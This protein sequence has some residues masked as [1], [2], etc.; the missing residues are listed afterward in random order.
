MCVEL[1]AFF[2]F[3]H[4][5]THCTCGTLP[6]D[7]FFIKLS[8]LDLSCQSV[9]SAEILLHESFL[10]HG[11]EATEKRWTEFFLS[12][13]F[14]DCVLFRWPCSPSSFALITPN[15]F[16]LYILS[17]KNKMHFSRISY[18]FLLKCTREFAEHC[19]KFIK[20]H[21][22]IKIAEMNA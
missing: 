22:N 3:Y 13:F 10:K 15:C 6:T 4:V 1:L 5:A 2:F 18:F 11:F 21:F 19:I 14:W 7:H 17:C 9:I 16:H 8:A 12:L 20:N